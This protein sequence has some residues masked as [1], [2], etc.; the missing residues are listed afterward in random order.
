MS[1]STAVFGKIIGGIAVAS[2]TALGGYNYATTGCVT[3]MGCSTGAETSA[4]ATLPV[5]DT[6]DD[7]PLGCSMDTGEATLTEV[8]NTEPALGSCCSAEAEKVALETK[9][10]SCCSLEGAETVKVA[11]KTDSCCSSEDAPAQPA[12]NLTLVAD[13]AQGD[14]AACCAG[15]DA[16]CCTNAGETCDGK[17]EKSEG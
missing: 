13:T 11:V 10:D 14:A 7:C 8:A 15:K 16:D 5:A 1:A 12:A 4:A 6:A 3:G 9:A 2:L 17:C